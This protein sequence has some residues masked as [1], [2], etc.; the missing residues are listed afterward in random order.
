[1]TALYLETW[2]PGI[3]TIPIFDLV[4]KSFILKLVTAVVN[5]EKCN[6]ISSGFRFTPKL[7]NFLHDCLTANV[8]NCILFQSKSQYT[9]NPH[10]PLNQ[11]K[12]AFRPP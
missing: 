11:C 8:D 12:L 5:K 9:F 1:M 7:S 4:R 10:L 3:I 2:T 6:G